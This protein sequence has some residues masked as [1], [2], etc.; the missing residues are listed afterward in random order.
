[1]VASGGCLAMSSGVGQLKKLVREK[2]LNIKIK[3]TIVGPIGEFECCF[4]MII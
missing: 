3:N 1:M 4:D 2:K